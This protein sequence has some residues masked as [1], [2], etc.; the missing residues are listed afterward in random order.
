MMSRKQR[1]AWQVLVFVTI[2]LWVAPAAA[3]GLAWMLYDLAGDIVTWF[4][5]KE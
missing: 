3:L 4:G 2:P 1:I 5:G